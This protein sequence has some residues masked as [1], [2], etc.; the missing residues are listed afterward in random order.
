[1]R[2]ILDAAALRAAL[3]D[4]GRDGHAARIGQILIESAKLKVVDHANPGRIDEGHLDCNGLGM[5]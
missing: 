1:V 2:A 3:S 5:C 4:I